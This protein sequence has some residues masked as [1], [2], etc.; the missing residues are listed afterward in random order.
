MDLKNVVCMCVLDSSGP[1]HAA[2][3]GLSRYGYQLLRNVFS[4]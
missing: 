3:M 1:E 2:M 4:S